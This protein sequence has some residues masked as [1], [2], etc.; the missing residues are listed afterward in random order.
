MLA[1]VQETSIYDFFLADES[2]HK[3]DFER[4]RQID[5]SFQRA[6]T[7]CTCSGGPHLR[8]ASLIL[9]KKKKT[10]FKKDSPN[11]ATT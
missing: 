7:Y 9:G 2:T 8:N 5:V 6:A 4:S 1:D 3:H 11:R 10:G